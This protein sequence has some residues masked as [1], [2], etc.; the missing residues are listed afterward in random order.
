MVRKL[1][2]FFEDVRDVALFIAGAPTGLKVGGSF[3]KGVG[4][5]IAHPK[6]AS[7]VTKGGNLLLKAG[8]GL[9]NLL[10]AGSSAVFK[11]AIKPAATTVATSLPGSKFLAPFAKYIPSVAATYGIVAGLNAINQNVKAMS[12]AKDPVKRGLM[13]SSQSSR[14]K[15]DALNPSEY[16]RVLKNMLMFK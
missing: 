5:S 7:V 14:L 12:Q 1:R 8:T 2:S 11:Q 10:K 4:A 6:V 9:G 16:W 13:S 15:F 3:L